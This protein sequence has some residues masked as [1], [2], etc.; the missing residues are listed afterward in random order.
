MSSEFLGLGMMG[1]EFKDLDY[2]GGFPTFTVGVP[3]FR[4]PIR[5]LIV[6]WGLYWVPL[7]CFGPLV[8]G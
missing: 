1:G 6:F 3:I 4:V 8:G 2:C 7:P 5:R